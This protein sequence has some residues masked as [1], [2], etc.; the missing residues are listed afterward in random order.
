[1]ARDGKTLVAAYGSGVGLL[2]PITFKRI[3]WDYT[4]N[5]NYGSLAYNERQRKA[6]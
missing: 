4:T 3:Y 5:S 6:K 2:D 1:M